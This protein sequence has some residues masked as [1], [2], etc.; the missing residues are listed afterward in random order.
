M[1][2]RMFLSLAAAPLAA[3]CSRAETAV[4]GATGAAGTTTAAGPVASAAAMRVEVWHDLVCPWCR[5]GL[6]NLGVALDAWSGPAVEVVLRPYLLEPDAPPAGFDLRERL[7][8][9]LGAPP[10]QAFARV[11]EAGAKYGVR[12]DWEK[13]R[14]SPATAKGHALLAWAPREKQRAVLEVLHHVHFE[15]GANL[16]DDAVLVQIAK[17]AGLDGDAARAAVNDAARIAEVRAGARAASSLGIDGVPHF[18]FGARRLHGAQSPEA[19]RAAIEGL[20]RSAG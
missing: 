9:K 2:R 7:Q 20:A 5:I 14:V 19:L 13:V 6:H 12:F 4:P 10:E 3:A 11:S 17:G 16:G 15:D 18:R 1:R 8:K